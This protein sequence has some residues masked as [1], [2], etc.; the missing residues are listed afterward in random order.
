MTSSG[1]HACKGCTHRLLC[2]PTYSD[3]VSDKQIGRKK[4]NQI[5]K[6]NLVMKGEINGLEKSCWSKYCKQQRFALSEEMA[7]GNFPC[8]ERFSH[9]TLKRFISAK[10]TL[11]WTGLI[12]RQEGVQWD[13]GK[14]FRADEGSLTESGMRGVDLFSF[15][16][17]TRASYLFWNVYL[18]KAE[19]KTDDSESL[20]K[21]K[22]FCSLMVHVIWLPFE[23]CLG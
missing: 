14:S 12:L 21:L 2:G 22:S 20:M 16:R 6:T 23:R 7:K 3:K 18:H 8:R 10:V 17:E 4:T 1:F 19:T 9:R 15:P 5:T 11:G 13:W